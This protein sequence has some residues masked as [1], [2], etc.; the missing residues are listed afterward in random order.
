MDDYVKWIDAEREARAG[1]EFDLIIKPGKIQA[2]H[3]YFFRHS[4]PA[5]FGVRVLAGKINAGSDIIDERGYPLGKIVQIQDSGQSIPSATEGK[6]VA[7][8][9]PKVILGR[10]VNEEDTL[11]I[12]V[13]Q[14]HAKLLLRKYA[15]MLTG[16]EREAL[17]EVVEI[18]RK[19]DPLW[20]V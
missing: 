19:K 20:A 15:S 9:M 7:V 5:I 10:N 3:G 17:D 4:K 1:K 12:D 16:N 14:E 2:L 11:F 6:E 13:P 18:K 8:S